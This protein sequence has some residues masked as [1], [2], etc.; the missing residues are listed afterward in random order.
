MRSRSHLSASIFSCGK[1]SRIPV[2]A[3]VVLI[4]FTA[5]SSVAAA[6]ERS[7]LVLPTMDA[8]ADHDM[9]FQAAVQ[10]SKELSSLGMPVFYEEEAAMRYQ[11]LGSVPYGMLDE[12][13]VKA[14]NH[15]AEKALYHASGDEHRQTHEAVTH[16]LAPVKKHPELYNRDAVLAESVFNVC[17]YEVRSLIA[18]SKNA[19]AYAQALDC[20]RLVLDIKPSVRMHPP[21]VRELMARVDN[22]LAS[23]P[24]QALD[25]QS[26]PSGCNVF[27]N[28]RR[29]GTTPYQRKGIPKGEYHVQIDCRGG[30]LNRVHRVKVG[31]EPT[32]VN[33]DSTFDEALVTGDQLGLMY[34][35]VSQENRHR[36]Q[37]A[38]RVARIVQAREVFLVT[39]TPEA[40]VLRVDRLPLAQGQVVASLLVKWTG[41]RFEGEAL[42]EGVPAMLAGQSLDLRGVGSR[43]TEAWQPAPDEHSA[44]AAH[45]TWPGWLLGSLGLL[46][47]GIAWV[48]A[49]DYDSQ[50]PLLADVAFYESFAAAGA[51]LMS[52]SLL[53][54]LPPEDGVPWWSWLAGAAGVGLGV[55]GAVDVLGTGNVQSPYSDMLLW[56]SVPLV[57]MPITYILR[58]IFGVED[59][60]SED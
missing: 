12:K 21:E 2:A 14:L 30:D 35:S 53:W 36:V 44:G 4:G 25:V 47:Y 40:Q 16:C 48:G 60:A 29:I 6:Q 26:E 31:G 41:S 38:L 56:G 24:E 46:S 5:A 59:N 52:S 10:F 33:I 54:L 22:D 58:T 18:Q 7:W 11:R 37:D 8:S 34:T 27:I 43:P 45:A 15:W 39:P 17:L 23:H 1:T 42:S 19:E 9:V 32:V 50:G 3:L 49:A 55:L 20:R 28:G 51:V 57:G 13:A